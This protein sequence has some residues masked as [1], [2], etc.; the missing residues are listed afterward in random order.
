MSQ[1]LTSLKLLLR[2]LFNERPIHQ[3]EAENAA[4]RARV[5]W[6]RLSMEATS[7]DVQNQIP[8]TVI[9][10]EIAWRLEQDNKVVGLMG[11]QETNVA[12]REVF[13]ERTA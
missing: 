11:L 10:K 2:R 13:N 9:A 12:E 3:V 4:L 1:W 5:K 6:L 8:R 7:R